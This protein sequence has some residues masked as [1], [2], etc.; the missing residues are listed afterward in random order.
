MYD[1]ITKIID[2]LHGLQGYLC[3]LESRITELENKQRNDD[4]F[5]N[6]LE[7]LLQTRNKKNGN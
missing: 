4:T 7:M 3:M 6:D 1:D 5:F 2:G